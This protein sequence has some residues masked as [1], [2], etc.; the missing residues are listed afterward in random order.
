[1]N[2]PISYVGLWIAILSSYNVHS[3]TLFVPTGTSGIGAS[4]NGFVGI[5]T[6]SPRGKFDV[7]GAGDIYLS[8]DPYA[9]TTQ[10]LYIPGHVYI[11]PYAGSNVSYFQ[12]RRPDNSGSTSLQFRTT[13]TG[14]LV[15]ALM[16]KSSGS[17]GIGTVDPQAKLDVVGGVSF[18]SGRLYQSGEIPNDNNAQFYNH[19]ATGYGLYSQGGGSGRYAFHFVNKEEAT[20]LYG[21]GDGNVGIGTIEP[22]AK[23]AVKGH[24]HTQEIRVDMTGAMVPD[25]VFEKNYNLR[26]L[27]QVENYINQNKHLPEVPSA[28]EMEATGVNLGEM[29][30]LLL[31]KVEELTLYVIELKKENEAQRRQNEIQQRE[32]ESIKNK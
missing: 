23:L 14:T 18:T 26:P 31:K 19:S 16:I 1:M 8:D 22:D 3:Q 27:A 15:E 4:T 28:K 20:I 11:S 24:I 25:Y 13:N 2:R 29:N 9:G 5:A 7:D 21:R 6:P 30:M 17:V 12:A 32:I 10:S